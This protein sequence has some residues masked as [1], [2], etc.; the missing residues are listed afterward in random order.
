MNIL[1]KRERLLALCAAQRD[2][3]GR[4]T[5]QLDGVIKV[6]DRGIAGVR[7]LRKHPVACG[8]VVGLFAVIQRRGML[9]WTQRALIAWRAYRAFGKSGF[10]S[11]F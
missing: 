5:Q 8:V 10:K 11:V 9:K 4:L 7:Y 2:E 3:L 6:A 1:Q